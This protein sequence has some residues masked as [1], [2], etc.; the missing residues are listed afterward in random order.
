WKDFAEKAL[1][2]MKAKG[3]K[4]A[5]REIRELPQQKIAGLKVP[6]PAFSPLDISGTEKV[7]GRKI[8]TWEEGLSEYLAEAGYR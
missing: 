2:K 8:S 7:L 3:G 6:R 1:E 4:V 5:C